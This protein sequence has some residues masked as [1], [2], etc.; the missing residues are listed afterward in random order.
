M[1]ALQLKS[2]GIILILIL[3]SINIF[4]Q[5]ETTTSSIDYTDKEA[6]FEGQ[7]NRALKVNF[8]GNFMGTSKISYEQIAKPGRAIELKLTLIE[9]GAEGAI[10]SIGYKIYKKPSFVAPHMQRRNILEG[11]YLK[12]E[13]FFGRVNYE[14]LIS[15]NKNDSSI[16]SGILLNLG[17]QWTFGKSF[18]IDTYVGTGIGNGHHFRGYFNQGG[19]VMT[20]G[21][22][23]GYAF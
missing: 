22:N 8:I 17:K 16:N 5:N 6:F 11:A 13:I 7:N 2:I 15:D 23:F 10:G 9:M 12:P 20:A 3:S 4:A 1:K 19:L 21:I 18:V 14:Y